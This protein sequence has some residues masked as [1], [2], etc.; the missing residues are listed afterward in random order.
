VNKLNSDSLTVIENTLEL[1]LRKLSRDGCAVE[2]GLSH[3][4]T[5]DKELCASNEENVS[6]NFKLLLLSDRIKDDVVAED[7]S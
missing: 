3:S 4:G 1:V 6:S 5:K 2:L 7:Y